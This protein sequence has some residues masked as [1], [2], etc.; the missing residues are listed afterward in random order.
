MIP[1]QEVFNEH[2]V[3]HIDPSLDM[4]TRHLRFARARFCGPLL[5]PRV[6]FNES[7]PSTNSILFSCPYYRKIIA[8][9]GQRSVLWKDNGK[10]KFPRKRKILSLLRR[11]RYLFLNHY[12][13]L[14]NVTWMFKIKANIFSKADMKNWIGFSISF[15]DVSPVSA[16][17]WITKL[18]E[19]WIILF[20]GLRNPIQFISY[21]SHQ[22]LMFK[23]KFIFLNWLEQ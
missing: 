7:L 22:I 11:V 8:L 14:N 3:G 1:E 16:L 5:R 4:F 12:N 2:F 21:M 10:L 18:R 13:K 6:G 15:W 23:K 19:W 20:Q 17:N 9:L